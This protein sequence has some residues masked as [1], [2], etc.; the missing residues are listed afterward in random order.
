MKKIALMMLFVSSIFGAELNWS[1]D[2]HDA[3]IKAKKEDKPVLFIISRD[4]CK[5][6]VLLKD[7]T[8]KDE[9]VIKAL[10]RDFISVVSWTNENDYIPD[11]LARATPGLP[12]IWFLQPDG[13]PM[14]QP[15][16]GYIEKDKFLEALAIVEQQFKKQSKGI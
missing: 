14:F 7:E 15:I 8:L 13:E 3:M 11:D 4:T 1:K 6:C 9:K 5:Y 12:G 16:L 10:N 2:Y